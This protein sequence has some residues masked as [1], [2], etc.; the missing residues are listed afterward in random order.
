MLLKQNKSIS[1][2]RGSFIILQMRMFIYS[3]MILI[4]KKEDPV[5]KS[6]YPTYT[7]KEKGIIKKCKLE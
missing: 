5:E 4:L 2:G 6:M 1:T 7:L 3:H